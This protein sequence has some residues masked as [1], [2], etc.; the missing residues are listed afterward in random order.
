MNVAR[1]DAPTATVLP[2]GKVLIAGGAGVSESD[3]LSSTELYDPATNT[4]AAPADTASMNVARTD[5]T[6]TLLPSGKVLIAGGYQG[7]SGAVSSTELYD[8]ATNTF[9]APADTA[10]M[11]VKRN[12]AT[13][14]LLPSGK[15]LIAAGIGGPQCPNTC[16]FLSSTELYDPATN[17]FAAPPIP[18]A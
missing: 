18:R 7:D 10:S 13:A 15:L 9:A 11:N 5:A 12:D 6:A 3:S 16:A 2:S 14:T 17:T 1:R 4:F 8:P